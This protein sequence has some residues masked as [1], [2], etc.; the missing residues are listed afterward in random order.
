VHP[1]LRGKL[2]HLA[3][4]VEGQ[5]RLHRFMPFSQS[6]QAHILCKRRSSQA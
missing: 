4:R 1:P 6:S 3:E 5:E 2:R